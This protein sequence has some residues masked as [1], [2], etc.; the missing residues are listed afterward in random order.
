MLKDGSA[1][2]AHA[3]VTAALLA[4]EGFTGA[5]ALTVESDEVKTLWSDLGRRWRIREQYFKAYPICRWAQ[6]AVE[7]ALSLKHGHRFDAADI[8]AIGIE[9]F[10]EAIDLGSQC[11][12][13][14]TTDEAQYSLPFPVAAALIFGK[15]GADEI[16]ATGVGDP[17]VARLLATI[18]LSEDDEFSR[19][20][21]AERWAR[22]RIGLADGRS[23]VSAP[24]QARGGPEH[25]LSGDELQAKYRTLAMP[26]LGATRAA[27]IETLIASIATDAAALAELLDEL[28][29]PIG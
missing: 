29:A 8:V 24:A 27:R 16:G 25:P 5:P 15:V 9:S 23:L 17:R 12:I 26:V 14:A 11:R 22:V 20:F 6:P 4:R 3:G 18:S 19:R 7:A 10:R 21:P 13:P 1:S 2:G 28:L